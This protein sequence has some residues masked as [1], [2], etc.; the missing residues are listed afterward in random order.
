MRGWCA[1]LRDT[2]SGR[3]STSCRT[4]WRSAAPQNAWWWD[5]LENGPSSRYAATSTSTGIRP[6]PSCATGS[7]CRSSA[8]TTG[9]C[10]RRASCAWRAAMRAS[11]CA[12]TTTSCRWRRARST[13]LLA[14]AAT[15]CGSEE[16]AAIADAFGASAPGDRR[17]IPPAWRSATATRRGCA[18]SSARL[19]PSSPPWPRPSTPRSPRSTPTSS[20]RRA[21]RAPELPPRLLAHRGARARLPALLRH[22]H[23]GRP[24]RGGRARLRRYARAGAALARRRRARRRA[25]R[26][27]R[28]AARPAS[29][30]A[31]PARRP[32]RRPGSSSR[33][34]CSR[35]APARD[36]AGRRHH[37][38]RLPAPRRRAVRRSRRARSRSPRC[39]A[40][41]PASPTTT[42]S[43]VYEKKHQ[44]MRGALGS[45]V[46]RLTALLVEVCERHR[47]H[48]DYTR[49]EL[50]EAVRE[51]IACF[52]S[53]APTCAPERPCTT[54][55]CALI[56]GAVEAAKARRPDLDAGAVRLPARPRIAARPQRGTRRQAG[57]RAGAQR[58]RTGSRIRHALPAAHAA[59]R[60]PR[61]S[62]TRPSTATTASWR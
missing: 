33:R 36:V 41:S 38:L 51:L 45:D 42:P 35:R 27:P 53:T 9:A 59:R 14:V 54:T 30:P 2:G 25:R 10:S 47:R 61:A 39:T 28:R 3:C 57:R 20:A 21:A 23:P 4:T 16:L 11:S 18:P 46:N 60:W 15:R 43:V 13:T 26:P 32:R 17:P 22:Q 62:R 8:T 24:A 31:A 52:P 5:V 1:A 19:A 44:V 40:S 55:T 48:R 49:H 58:Q 37:R 7:C 29:V 56:N 34:S 50:H 12:T 6:R